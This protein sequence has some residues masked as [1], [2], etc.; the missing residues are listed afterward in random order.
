MMKTLEE[1][2]IFYAED[3]FTRKL[4]EIFSTKNCPKKIYGHIYYLLKSYDIMLSSIQEAEKDQLCKYKRDC[5]Y[6]EISYEVFLRSDNSNLHDRF[7]K[8]RICLLHS[9]LEC[10]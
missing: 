2:Q 6:T 1:D 8:Y 3:F 5:L 9:V 10:H 4:K 7:E